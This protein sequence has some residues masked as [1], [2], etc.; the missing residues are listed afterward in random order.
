MSATGA[1]IMPEQNDTQQKSLKITALSVAEIAKVLS[2]ASGR[3]I[4]EE[5]VSEIVEHGNLVKPDG[6]V[7]LIEYTAFLV[8]ELA[9]GSD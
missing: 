8:R 6:T 3:Q 9:H 7:S 5:Q 4:T 1:K 2:S